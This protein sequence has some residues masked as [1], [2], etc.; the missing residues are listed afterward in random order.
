MTDQ[1]KTLN[2]EK[3]CVE[4]GVGDA[5]GGADAGGP[6]NILGGVQPSNENGGETERRHD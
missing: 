1:D 5:E 4:K 3:T 2:D 6:G